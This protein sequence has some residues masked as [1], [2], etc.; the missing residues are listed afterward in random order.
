VTI[1]VV[2]SERVTSERNDAELIRN[3]LYARVAAHNSRSCRWQSIAVAG[4]RWRD[5]F[6]WELLGRAPAAPDPAVPVR[7]LREIL[8]TVMRA[9]RKDTGDH[10]SAPAWRHVFDPLGLIVIIL[11]NSAVAI[12]VAGRLGP[13]ATACSPARI[14]NHKRIKG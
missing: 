8:V 10:A 1:P 5:A 6:S 11:T 2:T 4:S 7:I 13:Q 12:L 14:A 9:C 3:Q